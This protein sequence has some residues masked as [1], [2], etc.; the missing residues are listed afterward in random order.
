MLEV[1]C[2]WVALRISGCIW[3][4]A[5]RGIG[6]EARSLV[7][8]IEFVEVL[9]PREYFVL[10]GGV[11]SSLINIPKDGVCTEPCGDIEDIE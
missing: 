2:V 6:I 1:F 4:I 8:A 7:Q 3:C 9:I 11:S 5:N 10:Q